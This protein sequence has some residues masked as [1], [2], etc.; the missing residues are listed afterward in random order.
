MIKYKDQFECVSKKSGS[1][2]YLFFLCVCKSVIAEPLV[3]TRFQ[4]VAD[5]LAPSEKL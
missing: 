5:S 4:K 3:K 1:I 2:F